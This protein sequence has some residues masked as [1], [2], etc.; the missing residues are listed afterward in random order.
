MHLFRSFSNLNVCM[1]WLWK[2]NTYVCHYTVSHFKSISYFCFG[3][4]ESNGNQGIM[5]PNNTLSTSKFIVKI[6]DILF[7][8]INHTNSIW[9]CAICGCCFACLLFVFSFFKSICFYVAYCIF[10][11]YYV[12]DFF[13]HAVICTSVAIMTHWNVA[14]SLFGKLPCQRKK[15]EDRS[16]YNDATNGLKRKTCTL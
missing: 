9:L 14:E 5:W 11:L 13:F 6:S 10:V 16:I 1:F 4:V 15:K 8:I 3:N 12:L 2:Y 7:W